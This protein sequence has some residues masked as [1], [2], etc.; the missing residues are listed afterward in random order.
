[1]WYYPSV[2]FIDK[3]LLPKTRTIREDGQV[4]IEFGWKDQ[5]IDFFG[6]RTSIRRG[7]DGAV[8]T[9]S[10]SPYPSLIFSHVK[11]NEWDA[12]TRLCR[13]VKET[14]MW[15]IMAGLAVRSGEL[16]TAEIS[17]AALEESDKLQ[18]MRYIQDIPVPEGRA[19][20]LALFQRRL[21]EA[22][23]IL[24]QAGLHFRAIKMHINLFNWEH[25]L[26]LATNYMTHIDTVLAFRQ[27]HLQSF[28]QQETIA[29]FKARM[30]GDNAINLSWDKINSKI[31]EE[32]L[33]ER[34]RADA[35]MYK[36]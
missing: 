8:L 32:S 2:V 35:R 6:T 30:Q 10:I 14:F 24:L 34:S 3:D 4:Q 19:A 33:K 21:S 31:E 9:F 13:V 22:E 1:M 26:E 29:A 11:K 7:A 15:S 25:A 23:Q 16:K 36:P 28:G 18:Y 5:I 20:E 12:A 27:A 17:Y